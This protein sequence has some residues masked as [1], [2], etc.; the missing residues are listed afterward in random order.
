MNHLTSTQLQEYA[1]GFTDVQICSEIEVHLQTCAECTTKLKAFRQIGSALRK[2]PL[3]DASTD[4]T[5]MVMAQLK[6][7][8]SPSFIW[9]I[10]KNLAPIL[11]LV[12]VVG[13]VYTALK[14]SGVYD[15]SGVGESVKATQSVYNQVGNSVSNGISTFN[16]WLKNL[17]PFLYTKSSYGLAAFLVVLFIIVALLDKFV[18]MPM[19]RRRL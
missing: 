16:G 4:F 7:K 1:D 6:I 14:L 10:F 2:L 8:D 11:G 15:S 13:I 18:F 3:D 9:S 17:F 12:L 5:Q 19:V